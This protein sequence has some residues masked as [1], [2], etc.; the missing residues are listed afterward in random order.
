MVRIFRHYLP[1]KALLVA[2]LDVVVLVIALQL[3]LVFGLPESSQAAGGMLGP[4]PALVLGFGML[5]IMHCTGLYRADLWETYRLVHVALVTTLLCLAG[6]FYLSARLPTLSILDPNGPALM[7]AAIATGVML[8]RYAIR[9]W[10]ATTTFKPRI[11]VLGT[12]SRVNEFAELVQRN[13]N[14]V[15]VGYVPFPGTDVHHVPAS[16]LQPLGQ[17]ESLLALVDRLEVDHIVLGVRDRRGKLPLAELVECKL[18]G[19]RV[20]ELSAAF[21]REFRKVSLESISATWI[22]LNEGFLQTTLRTGLKRLFDLV[23]SSVL[24]VFAAPIIA[25]A[26]LAIYLESG[27]P[28][29]YRQERVGQGGRTFWMYKLRSMR[30]DAERD[31]KP[32]W[33]AAKDDRTTRVGRILRKIRVDELPQIINVF[34]GEMSFVGPRPERPYFVNELTRQLPYYALRHNVKPG[35]TG[36][37]QI[38]FPYGA[39]LEETAKKLQYDLYY[40]K[41]HALFLDFVILLATVGVVLTAKGAR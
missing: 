40:V 31:G 22:M 20:T 37:A 4:V 8:T 13:R 30:T 5:V 10:D 11:L 26:A 12:G 9:K 25:V 41:N 6:A 17:D 3:C 16:L 32:R 35:I 7:A 24:L 21:E 39:S 36:W 19:I 18:R 33:A 14:M 34:K 1:A 27:G 29:L 28:I 38:C 15:I 23:V 2:L